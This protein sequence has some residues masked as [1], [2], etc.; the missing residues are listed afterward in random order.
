MNSI[1]NDIDP[2]IIK[3]VQRHHI[4]TLATS[5]E[6]KPYCSTCFY[7]YE[8]EANLFIFTSEKNTRHIAEAV[9]QNHVAG[10]IALETKI[11]GKIRGVQ[12]TGEIK[13]L[14]DEELKKFRKAYLK[15]F[16]Y[17]TPFI[18]NTPFWSIEPDFFKLTDNNIGFGKKI[19]W[20]KNTDFQ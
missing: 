20:T 12:F 7:A 14:I 18:N 16:P 19:I 3:M 5:S 2:R 15:R 6:N 11:I 17:A 8:K 4:F 10:A 1:V 13:E 9:K